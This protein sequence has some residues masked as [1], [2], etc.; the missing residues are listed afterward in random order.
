MDIVVA[1][2]NVRRW[3]SAHRRRWRIA[4]IT[5]TLDH[6]CSG[7][8]GNRHQTILCHHLICYWIS[9]LHGRRKY[10]RITCS[11]PYGIKGR[12]TPPGTSRN[13]AGIECV[14]ST[15]YGIKGRGTVGVATAALSVGRCS[16]PYGIKGR[17]TVTPQ[18]LFDGERSAQRLTA[19]K[20]EAR[21]NAGI[22][23]AIHKVLNA[24]RHQR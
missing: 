11:T 13:S 16:T 5:H 15:P 22:R 2:R 20:V 24:L 6:H 1:R 7:H 17:G 12:G 10:R 18:T 8:T 23:H 19:S 4:G 14:C 21:E 9:C 3:V